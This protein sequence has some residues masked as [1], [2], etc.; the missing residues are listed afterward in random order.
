MAVKRSGAAAALRT[1]RL[2]ACGILC[3]LGVVMMYLG[4]VTDILDLTM[5][6]LSSLCIA[7]AVIEIGVRWAWLIWGVTA[8]LCLLLLPSKTIALLYLLGGMYPIA[9]SAFE[10][11]HPVLCWVLKF[12]MFN[13]VQLFFI[14]LAQKVLGL[15]GEGYEF[16]AADMLVNNVVFLLYDFALTACITLYLLRLRK[17]MKLPKLREE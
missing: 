15:S 2:T 5:M 9:K 14:L 7:F 6:M 10:R 8:A 3:A 16:I 1:R 17:R 4:A 11:L 13:T 12:S